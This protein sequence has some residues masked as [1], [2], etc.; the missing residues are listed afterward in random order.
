MSLPSQ[1]MDNLKFLSSNPPR[2]EITNQ[3]ELARKWAAL[4]FDETNGEMGATDKHPSWPRYRKAFFKRNGTPRP[5]TVNDVS[6]ILRVDAGAAREMLK[7]FGRAG[8]LDSEKHQQLLVYR[9]TEEGAT[10]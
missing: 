1:Q 10:A 2:R 9:L 8:Y 3:D 7:R 6:T 4:R 5:M